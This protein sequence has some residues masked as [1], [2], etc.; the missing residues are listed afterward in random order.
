[1]THFLKLVCMP[2]AALLSW[3]LTAA[4]S[5]A[6]PLAGYGT[7]NGCVMAAPAAAM[8]PMQQS[9]A[10]SPIF[11]VQLHMRT[12][13][14]PTLLPSGGRAHLF[15]EVHLSNFSSETLTLKGIEV[16]DAGKAGDDAIASFNTDVLSTSF[17]PIG[18]AKPGVDVSLA[19]GQ[20][21]VAF[22]CLAFEPGVP[23]PDAL[24]HRVLLSEG[25]LAGPVLRIHRTPLPV[26][27]PPVTGTDWVAMGHPAIDSHHRTGIFV[28]DGAAYLSRRYAIDWRIMRQGAMWS[29]DPLDVRAYYAYGQKV[30]AAAGGTVFD[31]R[32]GLPDNVPRTPAGFATALPVTVDNLTGNFVVVDH[33]KGQF[34]YYAHLQPGSVRVRKGERVRRGQQLGQIGNSGDARY[35]HLHF[36]LTTTPHILASEGL[37]YV[38]DRY[39]IKSADGSWE[40]RRGEMPLSS[41]PIDAGGAT[42]LRVR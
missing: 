39:R 32:D 5:S 38:L 41:M 37:P 17:F 22:L 11:P 35:P 34:A 28:I 25:T 33:G 13:V 23:A 18:F 42:P 6:A 7:P 9:A 4:P 15:Y 14:E 26:L 24:R 16:I 1:M 31:A 3:A 2:A 36:Q 20:T 19:A 21:T 40:L 27:G 8:P 29:G 12:P 10:N 30:I